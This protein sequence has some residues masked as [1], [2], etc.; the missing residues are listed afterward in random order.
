MFSRGGSE[1]SP[2]ASKA[3]FKF[4]A[5]QKVFFN[6]K[7]LRGKGQGQTLR[8]P[9]GKYFSSPQKVFFGSK[10]VGGFCH[11][12]GEGGRGGLIFVTKKWGFL[13]KASL[14]HNVAC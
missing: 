10:T 8:P 2:V 3:G 5:S 12:K 13:L 1:A 14:S 7:N 11:T 6:E 4:L 9:R